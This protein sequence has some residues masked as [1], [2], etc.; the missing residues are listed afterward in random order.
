MQN[1][2]FTEII[3]NV[4]PLDYYSSTVLS[5]YVIPG[6]IESHGHILQYGE[7]LESVLLYG[8]ES[9]QEVRERIKTFLNEHDGEGYGGKDKWIRGIGWDQAY[10]G[11]VMPT[12]VGALPPPILDA[13]RI[14]MLLQ[15]SREA[16]LRS[17]TKSKNH[18]TLTQGLLVIWRAR[19]R[20][21][22]KYRK[23][24]VMIPL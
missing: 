12:A 10:F 18:M 11:G 4:S 2:L 14:A 15:R 6:I 7:M 1:G 8:A 19:I 24:C 13:C 9:V 23:S 22:M 3:D 16:D 5:G 20:M 17:E 21:L